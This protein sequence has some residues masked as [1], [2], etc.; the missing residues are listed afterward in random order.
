MSHGPYPPIHDDGVPE[1]TEPYRLTRP[2][3][4][5]FDYFTPGL[6][7][8]W[9]HSMALAR[10]IERALHFGVPMDSLKAGADADR[11][12]ALQ[13]GVGFISVA[14][15]QYGPYMFVAPFDA[16]WQNSS[17]APANI[18]I[19][20]FGGTGSNLTVVADKETRYYVLFPEP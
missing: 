9:I 6:S 12:A 5:N 17:L 18:R 1:G 3:N 11:R 8:G 19:T 2:D 16:A 13:R 7:Y 15:S 4:F 20:N 10:W 14:E